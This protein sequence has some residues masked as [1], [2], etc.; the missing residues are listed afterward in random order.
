[1]LYRVIYASVKA[2]NT[3]PYAK[4]SQNLGWD[5]Q[6]LH[7]DQLP[8]WHLRLHFQERSGP[9]SSVWTLPST[10]LA[11]LCLERS[12]YT[13]CDQVWNTERFSSHSLPCRP[14]DHKRVVSKR[15]PWTSELYF[16]LLGG[17]SSGLTHT[18]LQSGVSEDE[19]PAVITLHVYVWRFF[20]LSPEHHIQLLNKN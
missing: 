14:D 20:P 13:N 12:H 6:T 19:E 2:M 4:H 16:F 7:I 18:D 5:F 3:Q 9:P 10:F 11:I 8:R 17:E 15:V 1:M